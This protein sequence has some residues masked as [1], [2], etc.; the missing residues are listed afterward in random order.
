MRL[1]LAVSTAAQQDCG[2]MFNPRN[3]GI[4][5]RVKSQRLFAG[6]YYETCFKICTLPLFRAGKSTFRPV[7]CRGRF[8]ANY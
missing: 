8:T 4:R 7:V 6:K 3:V 5:A 2:S 1:S